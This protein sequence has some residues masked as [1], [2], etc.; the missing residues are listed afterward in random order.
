VQGG[1]YFGPGGLGEMSGK[2][3]Q[4]DSSAESKELAK[5]ERLWK[6]SIEMTGVAPKI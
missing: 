4:V 6:L 3:R 2:A 5:A 1:L